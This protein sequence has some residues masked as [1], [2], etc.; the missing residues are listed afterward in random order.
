MRKTLGIALLLVV[1]F[2]GVAFAALAG[3][4]SYDQYAPVTYDSTEAAEEEEAKFPG[5]GAVAMRFAGSMDP[6]T[7]SEENFLGSEGMVSAHVLSSKL[8]VRKPANLVF[9]GI[10]IEDVAADKLEAALKGKR[11]Y[12]RVN[13]ENTLRNLGYMGTKKTVTGQGA[14]GWYFEKGYVFARFGWAPHLVPKNKAAVADYALDDNDSVTFIFATP[15]AG[16]AA[17]KGN[18]GSGGCNAG[19]AGLSLIALAGAFLAMR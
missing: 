1:A 9:F 6:L 2:V 16:H 13:N 19:F 7:T 10:T 5:T 4:V 17:P 18:S 8:G 12:A 11:L 3:H 15:S 14:H